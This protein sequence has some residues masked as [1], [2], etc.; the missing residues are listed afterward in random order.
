MSP[1][2]VIGLGYKAYRHFFGLSGGG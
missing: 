2:K 1:E